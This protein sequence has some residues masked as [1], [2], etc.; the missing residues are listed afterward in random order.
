M[1]TD[2]MHHV[3]QSWALVQP[4]APQA[5]ALFYGHLFAL[6]PTLRPLFKGDMAG[7]GRQL[8]RMI[9]AAVDRLGA[10]HTLIPVLQDLGRRHA[11]YGVQD[12]HYATVGSAL[13]ATLAQGLGE[14]FSPAVRDAWQQVYG[15]ISQTMMAA[16][17]AP[18]DVALHGA[19]PAL[20]APS[21]SLA[22]A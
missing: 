4:I 5:A 11:G 7:Q 16:A 17:A 6:D 22:A 8:M 10:P 3:Q 13:L 14:A 21:P 19:A 2:T 15:L 1:H 9:S 20:P 18:Q 12:C